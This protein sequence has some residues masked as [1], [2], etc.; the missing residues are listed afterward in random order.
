MRVGYQSS[1][2]RWE[3]DAGPQLRLLRSRANGPGLW[4]RLLWYANPRYWRQAAAA[5]TVYAS[6]F[7]IWDYLVR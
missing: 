5:I 6:M 1:V 7:M 3:E 4:R 2:A